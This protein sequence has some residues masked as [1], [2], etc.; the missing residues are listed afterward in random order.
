MKVDVLMPCAGSGQFF[1]ESLRS[2]LDQS[3]PPDAVYVIDNGCGHT[4]Y[5][6][7]VNRL[8][9]PLVRYV[10]FEERLP[11]VMNWQ[12]CLEVGENAVAAFLHDD[13]VWMPDYLERAVGELRERKAAL[14]LFAQTQFT[15]SNDR[16]PALAKSD[17][18]RYRKIKLLPEPL[19]LLSA[20]TSNLAHMS[21]MVFHRKSAGFFP[22]CHWMADQGFFSVYASYYGFSVV[23]ET[24]VFIRMSNAN[25]TSLL[26]SRGRTALEENWHRRWVVEFCSKHKSLVPDSFNDSSMDSGHSLRLFQ[27][28][29]SWPPN[30]QLL[31]LANAVLRKSGS[32][33]AAPIR[34]L[35]WIPRSLWPLVGLISDLRYLQKERRAAK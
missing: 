20:A 28:M 17:R 21:A 34:F 19:R 3:V 29:I 11:M 35:R 25:Q 33:F 9:S 13:D 2:A 6:D 5:L 4:A 14:V 32:G 15:E 12:R 7:V 22:N 1:E 18:E 26:V 30:F 24:G 27:A 16:P 31:N 8:A 23:D 10:R